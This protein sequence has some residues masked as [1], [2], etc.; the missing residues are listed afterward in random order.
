MKYL[1]GQLWLLVLLGTTGCGSFVAHRMV[2]APN[3]YP[4]W[5]APH[6]RVFLE[7]HPNFLTNFPAGTVEIGHPE[8]RLFYRIVEPADYHL[9]VASTNWFHHGHREFQ[10][11]FRADVPGKTNRWT[12]HPRGTVVLLHGYGLAQFTMAP[13]AIRLAQEGWCCVLVD[14]RGH[15]KSTGRQIYFGTREV[16]DLEQLCNALASQNRLAEPVAVMGESYGAALALRWMADDSRIQNAIAIAPYGSLSNA[17]LNICRDYAGWI[18]RAILRAGMRKLPGV[19]DV[20]PA[21]LDTTTILKKHPITALF[22]AGADDD[23]APPADVKALCALAPGSE[24][25]VVPGATHEAVTYFFDQIGDTVS[26][27]LTQLRK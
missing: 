27:W 4:N 24:L 17:V 25:V 2:Q 26:Q 10:F 14:L 19:L 23:V 20:P 16:H 18:P 7:F 9:R 13:W 1:W 8:A 11:N 21:E 6:P 15:G 12:A 3:R 5:L 22:I